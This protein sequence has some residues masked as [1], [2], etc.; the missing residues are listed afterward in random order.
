MPSADRSF[1]TVPTGTPNGRSRAT[2]PRGTPNWSNTGTLNAF[3]PGMGRPTARAIS[4]CRTSAKTSS[5]CSSEMVL[6]E[7]SP[8]LASCLPE[9]NVWFIFAGREAAKTL[10]VEAATSRSDPHVDVN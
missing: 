6:T 10:P 3:T 8:M 7:S 2:D 4:L 5:V 9:R 1:F